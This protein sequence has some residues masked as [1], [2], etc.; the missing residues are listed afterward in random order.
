[1]AIFLQYWPTPPKSFTSPFPH[2]DSV[3][4]VELVELTG[5]VGIFGFS[6][7]LMGPKFAF[8][9]VNEGTSHAA[10]GWGMQYMLCGWT[11]F[12]EACMWRQ[13]WRRE[14]GH[15]PVSQATWCTA[16]GT[17]VKTNDTIL[18]ENCHAEL[19][20]P[21]AYSLSIE[22]ESTLE[23]ATFPRPSILETSTW[24]IE[25]TGSSFVQSYFNVKTS[26]G[27]RYECR[28][29]VWRWWWWWC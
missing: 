11:F 14:Y 3:L 1:M 26:L 8:S 10:P 7:A 29:M 19:T 15:Y 23:H 4:L 6:I 9:R 5:P 16:K 18:L 2:L 24:K 25:T 12:A 27:R 20:N 21:Q 22:T 28:S 17:R 13:W